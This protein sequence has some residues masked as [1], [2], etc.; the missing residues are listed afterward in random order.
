MGSKRERRIERRLCYHWPVWFVEDFDEILSQGQMVDISSEAAAFTCYT[1][2]TC[3]FPSQ[4]ITIYFS[5]PLHGLGG[6]FAVRNFIRLGHTRRIDPIDKALNRV[7]AQFTE[8]LPF[9]PGE[10]TCSEAD[11]VAVLKML[12]LPNDV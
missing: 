4:L 8:R 1:Y 11:M 7:T 9:R 5:V 6:S 10:Q 12:S 2:E 3:L